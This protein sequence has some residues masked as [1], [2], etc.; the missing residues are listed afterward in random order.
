M[1]KPILIVRLP[2]NFAGDIVKWFESIGED[3]FVIALYDQ[4]VD[5]LGFEYPKN[6]DLPLGDLEKIRGAL[7]VK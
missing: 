4:E 7:L 1:A 6:C 5:D 3:Y 2:I